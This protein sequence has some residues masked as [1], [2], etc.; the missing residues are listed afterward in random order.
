[1]LLSKY[2]NERLHIGTD[3]K[4]VRTRPTTKEEL[5]SIIKQELEHQG[6]D[7]DLNFIDVSEIY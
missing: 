5:Q 3:T 6:P 7:A 2:I 4:T 1:M